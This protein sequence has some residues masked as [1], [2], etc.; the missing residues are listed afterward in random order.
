MLLY[1]NLSYWPWAKMKIQRMKIFELCHSPPFSTILPAD[2]DARNRML[3][4]LFGH[5][6]FKSQPMLS[7]FMHF[8][9]LHEFSFC[10]LPLTQC[11]RSYYLHTLSNLPEN[12]TIYI[13]TVNAFAIKK[14]K[15][16]IVRVLLILFFFVQSHKIQHLNLLHRSYSIPDKIYMTGT[17]SHI[18]IIN[19]SFVVRQKQPISKTNCFHLMK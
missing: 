6:I 19:Y 17:Q 18:Q 14:I 13:Y 1:Q 8:S 4:M 15:A 10:L 3:D 11:Y 5:S 12:T 9:L 7:S 16:S 2:A